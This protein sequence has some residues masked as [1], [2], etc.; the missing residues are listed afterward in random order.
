MYCAMLLEPANKH[1]TVQALAAV[2]AWDKAE[3]LAMAW[4]EAG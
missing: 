4:V 3:W 1:K 2:M